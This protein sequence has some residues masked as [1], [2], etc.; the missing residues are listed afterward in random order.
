[1][2][3]PIWITG[4]GVVSA[5][6]LD[7]RECLQAL[8]EER[9]GEITTEYN[10]N[11]G[12]NI[13][14]KYSFNAKE[15]D[16]ETGMYYYEARYYKPPVFTSRDAMMDQKPWLSPYHY[17][18]NNPIGRIDP[19]GMWDWDENGNLVA[20]EGD[21]YDNLAKFLGTT[22]NGARDILK[23]SGYQYGINLFKGGEVL[24]K[25]NL[26]VETE[27]DNNYKTI[28]N[29]I[30]A[31]QHYYMGNGEPVNIGKQTINELFESNKFK[32][33]HDDI[34]NGDNVDNPLEISMRFKTYHV[35]DTR[36]EYNIEKGKNAYSVT[37]TAFVRD[38]FWD[39]NVICELISKN[40]F[41]NEKKDYKGSNLELGG[42]PYNYIL[43]NR[44][45]FF[46]PIK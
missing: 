43:Y 6:G 29:T 9:S 10:A 5:I 4:C 34:T 33:A 42:T 31:I 46:K 26:W 20:H 40:I 25:D 22:L 15:L 36:M 19:T 11:F 39:P 27:N 3:E 35:G 24:D 38:G 12:N 8:L 17:C 21:N 32:K 23:R 1:M 41:H 18:S 30:E 44:T 7:K 16:E 2:P 14:P 13:L 37:Y 45:Y 28:N